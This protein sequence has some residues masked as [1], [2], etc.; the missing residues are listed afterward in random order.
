MVG[1][2]IF[3]VNHFAS[4]SG[5]RGRVER[6]LARLSAYLG[7]RPDF[8]LE[9]FLAECTLEVTELRDIPP[10][11]LVTLVHCRNAK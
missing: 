2:D 1:G 8:A 3:L 10:F 5:L 6:S 4:D 9:P 11:R 7:W